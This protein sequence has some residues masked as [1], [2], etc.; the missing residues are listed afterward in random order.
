MFTYSLSVF[1]KLFK[2]NSMSENNVTLHRVIKAAPE[3]V[4]RAFA[5][6]NAYSSWIPPY[7]FLCV[8]HHHGF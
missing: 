4:Y 6:S 1:K 2:R 5:D 3:K 7:G 8:V